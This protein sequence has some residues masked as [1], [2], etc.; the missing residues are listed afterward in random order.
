MYSYKPIHKA[1]LTGPV[2][3]L[4]TDGKEQRTARVQYCTTG[5]ELRG[6]QAWDGVKG[7]AQHGADK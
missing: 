3:K 4:T 2:A 1:L 7:R 5:D 6:A